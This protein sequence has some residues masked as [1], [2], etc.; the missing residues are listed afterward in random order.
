MLLFDGIKLRDE[1]GYLFIVCCADSDYFVYIWLDQFLSSYS[2][3]WLTI[4]HHLRFTEVKVLD[5][6]LSIYDRRCCWWFRVH[7]FYN[8][9]VLWRGRCIR[10]SCLAAGVR[11]GSTLIT[12][13]QTTAS[14][15][16]TLTVSGNSNTGN[17]TGKIVT[18]LSIITVGL[19]SRVAQ[20]IVKMGL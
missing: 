18:G 6:S 12:P 9:L 5:W 2:L 8:Y 1:G 19:Q 17:E 13:T 11:T 20:V 7:G 10:T 14:R 16:L 4:C 15:Y 3:L